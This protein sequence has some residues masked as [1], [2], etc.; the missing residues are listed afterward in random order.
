MEPLVNRLAWSP[1]RARTFREGCPRA[2]WFQ[3]YGSWGGWER[4]ATPR[5][6]D[7]WLQKKLTTRA[8]W[9]GTVV[10]GAAERGLKAAMDG[11]TP[12]VDEARVWAHDV[13][14]RHIALSE[15]GAWTKV[16]GKKLGFREHYYDE[17][18]PD[19]YFAEGLADIARL[20]GALHEDRFYRRMLD[21]AHKIREVE[22]LRDFMVGDARV[23][24]TL[25]VLMHDGLGGVVI[26][27]WKT[28]ASHDDAEIAAQLG[29][30]GLYAHLVIGV[31]EDRVKAMHVNLRTGQARTHVVGPE[32]IAAARLAIE[33]DTAAMRARLVDVGENVAREEDYPPLPEGS[34][35]CGWCVFRGVCGRVKERP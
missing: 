23:L 12:E 22:V 16:R 11:V 33:Q 19:G 28:G 5:Q 35:A 27:D 8:A 30:Y 18:V 15:S 1:S 4:D 31:P 9:I 6:R 20:V 17:P 3:Y 34:P 26:V 13:A 7:A 32:Q 24:V 2:Y 25:D 21:A 29:A 14:S 10:H